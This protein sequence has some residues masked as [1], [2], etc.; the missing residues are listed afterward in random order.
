MFEEF[1]PLLIVDE[2]VRRVGFFLTKYGIWGVVVVQVPTNVQ[3]VSWC[4]FVCHLNLPL[5]FHSDRMKCSSLVL[6]PF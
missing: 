1:V 4:D 6:M 3:N 2:V 5:S